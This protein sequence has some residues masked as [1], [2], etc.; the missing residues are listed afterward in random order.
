M[1]RRW[2]DTQSSSENI[3]GFLGYSLV[4]CCFHWFHSCFQGDFTATDSLPILK[5]QI[6]HIM[7]SS[8]L[9]KSPMSQGT[10][11]LHSRSICW[12]TVKQCWWLLLVLHHGSVEFL[13]FERQLLE[14][15]LFFNEPWFWY[16]KGNYYVM[17]HYYWRYTY[18]GTLFLGILRVQRVQFIF[19]EIRAS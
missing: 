6:Q 16:L 11:V 19:Q 5:P 17:N 15:H 14:I 3:T 2:V 12:F 9:I 10:C 7:V 4:V 8:D 13:V 18:C 1:L